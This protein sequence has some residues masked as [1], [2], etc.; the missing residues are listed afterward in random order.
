MRGIA[1]TTGQILAYLPISPS[2]QDKYKEMPTLLNFSAG[3][4]ALPPHRNFLKIARHGHG[5]TNP[6]T[7]PH[8]EKNNNN[9]DE[10]I[11]VSLPM[12]PPPS[13]IP[14]EGIE[15][16]TSFLKQVFPSLAASLPRTGSPFSHTR[17]C[18]Y[19]DTP[20]GD[21]IISQHPSYASSSLLVATGGNGHGF[22]FLPILGDK[23]V[24]VL[25]GT[26]SSELEQRWRWPSERKFDERSWSGDGSRGGPK[27]MVLEEELERSGKETKSRL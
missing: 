25:M 1:R 12:I 10:E 22:K 9:N 23:I 6:T 19:L 18:Y 8:P 14:D 26:V 16:C 2:V 11:T 3:L 4:F 20:T 7:I 15:T 17:I 27:G 5:Y 24:Q 13:S 21:F